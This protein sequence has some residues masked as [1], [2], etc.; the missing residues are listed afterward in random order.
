MR[1]AKGTLT[2]LPILTMPADDI[3]HPIPDLTGYI[4]E[5]QIVLVARARPHGRLSAGQRAA[6]PVAAHEGRHRQGDSRTPTIRRSRA[7]ST[8]PTREAVQ[9]RVLASVV[10]EEGLSD[11]DRD[12]LAFGDAFERELIRQSGRAH[13]RREHGGRLAA[14]CAGCRGPSWRACP[15]RRSSATSRTADAHERRH[16][17]PQ[18]RPRARGRA[19]GDARGL[20]LPR[21]EVPAARRRDAARAARFERLRAS[22]LGRWQRAALPLPG[23]R[24]APRSRGPAGL[25]AGRRSPR[26]VLAT[27]SRCSASRCR[28]RGSRRGASAEPASNPS[29]EAEACRAAFATLLPARRDRGDVGNLERL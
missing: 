4:T 16:P 22:L 23:A 24:S 9:A 12:Y 15:T 29:P 1:G 25:S 28:R 26:Q 3:G 17:H 8:P 11:S 10:G 14:A 5:G 21:R 20:R 6:E 7:S 2:Q 13:P 18:R 27:R 19:P